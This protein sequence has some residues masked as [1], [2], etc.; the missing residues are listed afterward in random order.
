MWLKIKNQLLNLGLV[1]RIEVEADRIVFHPIHPDRFSVEVSIEG[2]KSP[3]KRH[4]IYL[5]EEE[6]KKVAKA[7]QT[8][9]YV[10]RESLVEI[11][12]D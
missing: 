8:S 10:D 4:R 5:S 7:V 11:L 3:F 12:E 2:K 6:F 1:W 9:F